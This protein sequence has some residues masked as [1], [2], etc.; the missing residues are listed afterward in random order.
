[1]PYPALAYLGLSFLLFFLVSDI[2]P[3]VKINMATAELY[4]SSHILLFF[5]KSLPVYVLKVS[6]CSDQKISL[7]QCFAKSEQQ[8]AADCI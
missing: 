1:M 3:T 7:F 4:M 2:F 5:F 8:I 6:V